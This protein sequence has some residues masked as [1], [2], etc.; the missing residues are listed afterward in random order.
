MSH[1]TRT[2]YRPWQEAR[3]LLQRIQSKHRSRGS[4][5]PSFEVLEDRTLLSLAAPLNQIL[6]TGQ[7]P[8]DVKLALLDG[9]NLPDVA[10]LS[11]AG[12]LTTAFNDGANEWRNVQ[13]T[14]LGIG[15]ADGMVFGH[16]EA[17]N[18]ALD[19]A[20]QGP[21]AITMFHG[22]GAGHFTLL[23]TLSAPRAGSFAPSGGGHVDLHTVLL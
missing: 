1:F 21:N 3:S 6:P 20:V 9:D 22:D 23:S 14:S 17:S 18:P 16:F 8:I 19:L 12:S 13:T 10:V 5:R 7:Q 2:F 15:S 11:S 4:Y